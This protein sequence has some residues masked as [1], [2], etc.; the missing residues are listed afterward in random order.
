MARYGLYFGLILVLLCAPA[1]A[2]TETQSPPAPVA[3]QPAA[4]TQ[5][6]APAAPSGAPVAPSVAPSAQPLE[7]TLSNA[8]VPR[9]LSP[10]S[11]FMSADILVKAVMVSLAFASFVTWTILGQPAAEARVTL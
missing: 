1:Q 7:Q 5:S 2:Q 4:P 8:R 11:M 3:A 9:E 6:A 10:W